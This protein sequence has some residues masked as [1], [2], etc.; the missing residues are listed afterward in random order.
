MKNAI[1]LC[2]GGLDSVVCAHQVKRSGEYAK[3]R[4]LFFDY[5]QRSLG[6]ERDLSKKC[7]EDLESEFIEIE[8]P[9][10]KGISGALTKSG[11]RE[12]EVSREDLKK[13]GD[14]SVAWYFPF[15]NS[16]FL[17]QAIALAEAS[18]INEGELNDL[19]VGFKC[20]G[21]DGFPDTSE[22][23]VEHMNMLIKKFS[24]G[25]FSLKAPLIKMDKED[26]VKLG[27][28]LNIDLSKTYSCYIGRSKHCGV[29]LACRLRQEGFYWA[30][31]KDKTDYEKLPS[32]YR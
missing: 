25:D 6:K 10:V 2:S 7:A 16:V 18:F 17:S 23:Y 19:F 1:I 11:G 5:G 21:N 12:K 32:D 22:E 30:N 24:S 26:I 28:E 27:H 13:S 15:R 20:E 29:C 3:I 31:I 14:L 8:L 4:I 9:R